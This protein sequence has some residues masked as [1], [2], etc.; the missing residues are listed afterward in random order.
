MANPDN[1]RAVAAVDA[2]NMI[3]HLENTPNFYREALRTTKNS[4]FQFSASSVDR[5]IFLGMG[6]SALAGR[7]IQDW[8]YDRRSVSMD[9]AMDYVLPANVGKN[10][11]VVAVSYSGD[12][13]ETLTAATQALKMK[14]K[15]VGISSG[16]VLERLCKS[17]K[18][19][20]IKVP[21]SFPSRVALPFLLTMSGWLTEVTGCFRGFLRELE[22]SISTLQKMARELSVDVPSASNPAKK[23]A[24]EIATTI[25]IIYG[26]RE[27]SSVAARWKAQLNENG[28]IMAMSNSLPEVDHNE[29]VGWDKSDP[30]VLD[31]LS[32]IF[33]RDQRPPPS[34]G[35]RIEITK[36]SIKART[37]KVYE[38]FSRGNS[39]LARMLSAVYLGDFV[40]FYV[41]VI[42][43]VNP[44]PVEAILKIKN[45]LA[46]S[47]GTLDA[48]AKKIAD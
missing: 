18:I 42:R 9:V 7:L 28:K 15:V 8:S 12:T 47:L 31:K 22:S 24:L 20:H 30:N 33:I 13:E 38:V 46:K 23:M 41:A 4:H 40:S 48:I 26:Y 21:Q 2:D 11:L 14:A 10:T 44:T 16:G 3:E 27:Y 1:R 17:K 43:N 37:N 39:R 25:P 29:I 45:T 36:D 35:K 32:A 5:I 6:A 19:T 34:I